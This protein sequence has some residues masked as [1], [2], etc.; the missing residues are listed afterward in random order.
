MTYPHSKSFQLSIFLANLVNFQATKMA[1]TIFEYLKESGLRLEKC[2]FA[3]VS[4]GINVTAP[5]RRNNH[6]RH[7]T[8]TTAK[9]AAAATTTAPATTA[10]PQ[11][12]RMKC[13][14]RLS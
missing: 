11:T 5:S 1:Q 6:E 2:W 3:Q 7:K 8:T 12:P 13:Y 4:G 9:T 10:T 14:T